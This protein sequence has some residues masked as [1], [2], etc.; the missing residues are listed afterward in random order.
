[1]TGLV[2]RLP[3]RDAGLLLV[4]LP[5]SSTDSL[6]A[7]LTYSCTSRESFSLKTSGCSGAITKKVAPNRVSGRVVKTG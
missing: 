4:L 2:D 7:R 1:M 6:S 5:R 3:E